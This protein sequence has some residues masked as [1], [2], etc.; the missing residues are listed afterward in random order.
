M[1]KGAVGI[2]LR[3]LF[4]VLLI[5]IVIRFSGIRPQDI[6]TALEPVDAWKLSGTLLPILVADRL[7]MSYK[8][9]L[10]LR[11]AGIHIS[12]WENIRLYLVSSFVGLA[13]PSSVGADLVRTYQLSIRRF[14]VREAFASVVVER[15]LA[16]L[17]VATFVLITAP[18]L[19][20]H[21]PQLRFIALTAAIATIVIP[22]IVFLMFSRN[23]SRWVRQAFPHVLGQ[24]LTDAAGRI[25][26]ALVAYRRRLP[27]LGA[28]FALSLVETTIP[29]ITT[30]I[31]AR[32]L[33]IDASWITFVLVVPLILVVI[34]IP[35][36]I[37][38]VGVIELSYVYLLVSMGMG[39]VQA[40]SL[41]LLMD[42]IGILMSLVGGLVLLI[43]VL[44]RPKRHI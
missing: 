6:R 28:F 3:F 10:L 21:Y 1:P 14:E 26:D 4:S 42:I 43:H 41:G 38:G 8:W 44:A 40:L 13:L 15:F 7:L 5:A 24:R 20:L 18:F 9:N 29:L 30:V 31:V 39:S 37:A 36:S 25:Y 35:I 22:T 2:V 27:V 16:F 33:G 23:M 32:A 34:R 11:S 17:A 19:A 12:L